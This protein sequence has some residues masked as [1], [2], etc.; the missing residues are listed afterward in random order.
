MKSK[1]ES[2]FSKVRYAGSHD[3]TAYQVRDGEADLGA[4][5]S[6][7]YEAMQQSGRLKRDDLRIIW[8]TPPYPDYVWAVQDSIPEGVV[9]KLRDAF[10][11]LEQGNE[12]HLRILSLLSA[13]TFLPSR[14]EDFVA[15]TR[16]TERL[17]LSSTARQ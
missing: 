10:L 17:R 13:E 16:I 6:E 15:L 5:N 2:H 11:N 4:I 8:E 7:V 12:D 14:A 3:A 1:P 9:I